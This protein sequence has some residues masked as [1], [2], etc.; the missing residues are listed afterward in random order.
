MQQTVDINCDMGESFGV[1]RLGDDAA[2]M[3]SITSAN[4]ACGFHAG[5]PKTMK[6]TVEMAV[7]HGVSVGAHPGF[8]DLVG[9]GR[10]N[11]AVSPD[12]AYADV[13]Y[14]IGAL[15][16]FCR[17]Y[18]VPLRHVKPHGQLNNMAFVDVALADAIAQAVFDFDP[19]LVMVSYGGALARAAE[20][21]G[22]TVAYEIYADRAYD[23]D[24]ALVPRSLPGAVISDP[25]TV[26]ERV[27]SM[28]RRQA[29]VSQSGQWI[30]TN[31]DTI[32][33][34]GDTFGATE[35]AARV[36]AGLV[37]AGILIRPLG[38]GNTLRA[39]SE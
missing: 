36:K 24:G 6:H 5:D 34:H 2:M 4:V 39:R 15:Q 9:F 19:G 22:L 10:R 27:I 31:I 25:S 26:V 38:F 35:L 29:I 3:A 17:S 37:E 13:L 21:R 1:Y 8:P 14:Q 11:L 18:A 28:V 7:S 33:V 23:N 32:C 30:P 20:K 16:A 12:D